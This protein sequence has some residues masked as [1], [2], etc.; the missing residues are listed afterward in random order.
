MDKKFI[1]LIFLFLLC[2]GLF[3]ILVVFKDPIGTYTRAKEE[4][5]VSAE[6]SGILA[7]PVQVKADGISTSTIT[8]F[9]RN[10]KGEVLG[11][12]TIEVRGSIGEIK[13]IS[14]DEN[15]KQGIGMFKITSQATGI[16]K[17]TAIIDHNVEINHSVTVEFN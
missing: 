17:I 10:S 4:T 8:V 16:A 2:F 12:K 14:T 6:K 11:N 3:F 15:T 5:D 13:D 7:F 1:S 9:S